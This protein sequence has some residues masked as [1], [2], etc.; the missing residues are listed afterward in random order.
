M[1]ILKKQIEGKFMPRI[2]ENGTL[3]YDV[4]TAKCGLE[5]VM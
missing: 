4:Y 5:T 1:D 3:C 2:A